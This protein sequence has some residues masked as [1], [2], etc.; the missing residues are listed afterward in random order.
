MIVKQ[1]PNRHDGKSDF[2]ELA[3]Y[4]TG[5][6]DADEHARGVRERP[7]FGPLTEY[8]A[9][10]RGLTGQDKC[11]AVSLHRIRSVATAAA[12]F[13]SVA[14]RNP[15]VENPVVHL[16]VSWPEHERPSYDAIFAAGRDVLK[17]LN[18]HEHQS[19]MAIHNDTDNLH[20]HIEVSRVHPDTYKSQHLPWMHR[21]LHRAARQIEIRNGWFHDDGLFVVRTLPDGRKVVVPNT[22][23]RDA[24]DIDRSLRGEKAQRMAAWSDKPSLVEYCREM[25][26]DEMARLL[27]SV[28]GWDAV[29]QLLGEHGMRIHKTGAGAFQLEA[30]NDAGSTIL[31]P[32]SLALRGVKLGEAERVMGPFTPNRKEFTA[33]AKSSMSDG[34]QEGSAPPRRDP[35]RREARRLERAAERSTL[36]GRYRAAQ[37]AARSARSV[38]SEHLAE[39]AAWCQAKIDAQRMQ[40]AA[41][42][43]A[44]FQDEPDSHERKLRRR[45]LTIEARLDR[46]IVKAEAKERCES[47]RASRPAPLAWRTWLEAEAQAGNPAALKALRG[48]VYDAGRKSRKQARAGSY[49]DLSAVISLQEGGEVNAV[50]ASL[51]SHEKEEV[52]IRSAKSERARVEQADALLQRIR[53]LTWQVTNNGNV[54]YRCATGDPVFV[55]K[56]TKLTFDRQAVTDQDLALTMLHAREKWGRTIVLTGGD[57]IFVERM[58]KAAV[59]AGM[60]VRNPELQPVQARYIAQQART[61]KKPVMRNAALGRSEVV[62]FTPA[63]LQTLVV[64]PGSAPVETGPAALSG[65]TLLK[66]V[67]KGRGRRG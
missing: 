6:I 40:T 5:G 29:H 9:Q 52:S 67:Q 66:T 58:V 4:I 38:S 34:P 63:D 8:V 28:A 33:A 18:L 46:L 49:G 20:C 26:K 44:L 61:G 7:G 14:M 17:A 41:A 47:I 25:V 21:T 48:L 60:T 36:I 50:L 37:E 31:L 35:F 53:G 39:V 22:C 51:L 13:H 3:R 23:Y 15:N 62:G 10:A 56:G 32:I 30:I 64:G 11:V 57:A 24:P 59:S 54:E 42:K 2:G 1:V 65:A 43:E 27:D 16:I 55:D 45:D 12:Q 19:L